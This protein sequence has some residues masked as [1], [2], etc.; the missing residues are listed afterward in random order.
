MM[1]KFLFMLTACV[2]MAMSTN[3][4]VCRISDSNDNV[5]VFSCYLTDN[6]S[7]VTVTVGNDSQNI[8][9]NVTITVEV[10]YNSSTKKT[11]ST[12]VIA[13]P[14]QTTD[15]K[16]SIQEKVGNI[17]AKSVEVVSI[18]GTKCLQ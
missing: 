15:A 11:Y 4:Q 13:K 2:C 8:S 16:I 14:N 1:K 9:A 5:E 3:A 7:T 17:T 18:T 12:K 10:T 6:N